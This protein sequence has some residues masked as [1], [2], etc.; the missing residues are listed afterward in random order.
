M[1][2]KIIQDYHNGSIHAKNIKDGAMFVIKIKS[3]KVEDT[4]EK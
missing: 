4:D 1:S 2:K 3:M